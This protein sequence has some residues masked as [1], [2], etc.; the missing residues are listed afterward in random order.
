MRII[1]ILILTFSILFGLNA[2]SYDDASEASKICLAVQGNNFMNDV[3]AEDALDRILSVIGASKGFILQPCGDIQNAVVTSYK[4]LRYIL[5][6]KDFMNI[7]GENTNA[8][9]QL[10]ILAHEVGHHINGHSVDILLAATNVIEPKTLA[11]KRQ[12]ELESDEFAGF[13]LAKLGATLIESSEAIN[14]LASNKDDT[15]STHPS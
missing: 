6:N 5:Y 12:Q 3:E 11:S 2:Q 13:I 14:L 8:W 1:K 9:S 10:F 7:I 15:Y 4:G